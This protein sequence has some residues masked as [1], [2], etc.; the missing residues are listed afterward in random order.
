MVTGHVLSG[1]RGTGVDRNRHVL[2]ID[3]RMSLYHHSG[4]HINSN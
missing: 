4:R 1:D 3:S 2:G